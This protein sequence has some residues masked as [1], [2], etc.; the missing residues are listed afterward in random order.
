VTLY[1]DASALVAAHLDQPG[2]VVVRDAMTLDPDWCSSGLTLMES[3][4]L[5]DRVAD[6][7]LV[8][9]DLEDLV[10]LTWDRLAVV[11]VDQRCLDRAAALMRSQPLRLSDA[12]HLAAADRLP[13]P[14][15]FV[16]FDPAQI[17][18]ALALGF[19]VVS[20]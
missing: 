10:R 13:R 15:S 9:S 8:R 19:D 18:V 3:L 12:L 14:L 5:I 11:P 20:T 6:D 16:T 7:A 1:L 17:P 4:A 2:R